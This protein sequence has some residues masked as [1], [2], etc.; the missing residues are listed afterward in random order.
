MKIKFYLKKYQKKDFN[1][2][3]NEIFNKLNVKEDDGYGDWL[4]SNKDIDN[5]V[6]NKQNL[7]EI[8]EKKMQML[9]H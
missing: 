9:V 4:K 1:K 6:A 2:I 8:F 5:D 3:F 7:H